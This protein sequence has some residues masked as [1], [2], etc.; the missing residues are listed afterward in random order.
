V[1]V[2]INDGARHTG[3]LV[4]LGEGHVDLPWPR[5]TASRLAPA[6]RLP[7]GDRGEG[8]GWE[9]SSASSWVIS[10]ARSPI[11]P[12]H[13]GASRRCS[14]MPRTRSSARC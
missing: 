6:V 12:R 5:K 1:S 7:R 4:D 13:P 9:R 11:D 14:A 8:Q 3:E 10:S 2:Y